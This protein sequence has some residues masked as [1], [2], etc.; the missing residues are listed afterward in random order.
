MDFSLLSF[1]QYGLEVTHLNG[2]KQ[3]IQPEDRVHCLVFFPRKL[4][5]LELTFH[6]GTIFILIHLY[7]AAF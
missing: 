1:F 7:V 3:P 6:E 5:L 4:L 2:C